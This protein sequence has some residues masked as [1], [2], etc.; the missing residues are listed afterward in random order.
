[1]E[2]CVAS[3][4]AAA[5]LKKALKPPSFDLSPLTCPSHQL[6]AARGNFTVDDDRGAV[7]STLEKMLA[8]KAKFYE[9]E[10][11]DWV[12][13]RFVTAFSPV[14]V[15]RSVG[16][17]AG[18]T[19]DTAGEPGEGAVARMKRRMRWRGDAEEARHATWE[20]AHATKG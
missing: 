9:E 12:L 18:E 10:K 19:A 5:A 7:N 6:C 3:L 11:N 1:M 20:T 8:A 16:G 15:P 17:G 2:R 14:F 13:S 4:R